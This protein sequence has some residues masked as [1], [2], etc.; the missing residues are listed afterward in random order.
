MALAKNMLVTAAE[1]EHMDKVIRDDDRGAVGHLV[2]I[3]IWQSDT[4]G[5]VVKGC[6]PNFRIP[7]GIVRTPKL[8]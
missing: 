1:Q 7:S 5:V 6:P 8:T 3:E 4:N 2:D